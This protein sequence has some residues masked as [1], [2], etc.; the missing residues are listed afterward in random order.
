MDPSLSLHECSNAQDVSW[1]QTRLEVHVLEKETQTALVWGLAHDSLTAWTLAAVLLLVFLPLII[2]RLGGIPSVSPVMQ[3]QKDAAPPTLLLLVTG[4]LSIGV[5]ANITV[6]LTTVHSVTSSLTS[7]GY[8]IAS[9]CLGAIAGLLIFR[10]LGVNSLK[11]AYQLAAFSMVLGNG[12]YAWSSAKKAGFETLIISRVVTGFGAG[13]MYN[14]AMVMVHFARGSQKTSYMVLYQFFVALGV[15]LGPA[16]A[17]ASI[18]ASGII[19]SEISYTEQDAVAS[20]IMVLYGLALWSGILLLPSDIAELE[21]QAGIESEA[22]PAATNLVKGSDVQTDWRKGSALLTTLVASAS[23]RMTQRLLWESG[24]VIAV[25]KA[26]GW[27]PSTAGLM[28]VLVVACQAA[29]QFGFSQFIAGRYADDKLLRVLELTQLLGI[30]IMFQPWSLPQWLS[31]VQ[32][33]L[34]SIV[35]YCSNAL[36]SGVLSAFCVKRSHAGTFFSSENLMLFN[37]AAIFLGIALGSIISRAMQ[38]LDP[39]LNS[40]AATLLV[41]G[42]LQLGLS[43]IA[44]SDISLD[45]IVPPL[46]AITAAA[47]V[48][49]ALL[50]PLG[51]TGSSNVFSWHIV[52]MGLAWPLFSHMGYWSYKADAFSGWEKNDRRTVHMLCMLCG[53]LFMAVGYW[54]IF[55]AHKD[56]GEGQLGGLEVQKGSLKLSRSVGRFVHVVLGYLVLAGALLQIPMGLLKRYILLRDGER[57]VKWHGKFGWLLLLGSSGTVCIG[58]WLDFNSAGGWPSWLKIGITAGLAGLAA[59]IT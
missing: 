8:I 37:Q 11:N 23:V 19:I 13:S 31:I 18:Y 29:A 25:H 42:L 20:A 3:N 26:Y 7:S 6:I 39:G 17:S 52:C 1:L 32:F 54:A 49:G 53:G 57:T 15:L 24:S 5:M 40:L 9:D 44:I 12:M 48:A 34:A 55:K 38:E 2:R 21:K 4:A 50:V 14:T 51:G 16:L 45:F 28:Y 30:A 35:A 10:Q 59:A 47:I 41:G 36:W 58:T 33:L 22:G 56:N 43:L 27:S 46:S